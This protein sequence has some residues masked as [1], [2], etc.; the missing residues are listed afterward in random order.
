[1]SNTEEPSVQLSPLEA[2]R[3]EVAQYQSNIDMFNSILQTLPS[4]LPAHLEQF[5]S[6]QDRHVAIAEVDDL[7]DVALLSDVWFHDEMKA[8]I[9]SE[10][11]EMRKAA[12]ILAVMESNA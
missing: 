2:R 8:R 9:R 3:A 11:V 5:R 10:M 7:D 4:E 1:M 12:A 6:R